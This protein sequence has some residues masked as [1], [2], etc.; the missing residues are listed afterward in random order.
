MSPASVLDNFRDC[1]PAFDPAER[2]LLAAWLLVGGA[3]YLVRAAVRDLAKWD[4]R[5]Y[6]GAA[7]TMV[8]EG[9]WLVPQVPFREGPFLEKP[10]LAM[11]LE[12]LSMLVVGETLTAVR[13][14]SVLATLGTALAVYLIARHV[15][16]RTAGFAAMGALLAAPPLFYES[17][18]GITA[19]TDALLLLFGTAFVWWTWRGADR[20][21]LLPVAGVAAGLAVLTKGVAAG[22]FAITVLPFVAV[23]WRAYCRRELAVAVAATVVVAVPWN[24]AVFARHP[25]VYVDQMV[26]SQVVDRAMG[27]GAAPDETLLPWMNFPY[28]DLFP[29]YLGGLLPASAVGALVAL[30]R[31]PVSVREG[32]DDGPISLRFDDRRRLTTGL[33]WWAAAPLLT[34]SLLGGNHIWYLLPMVAPT[35]VL[36]GLLAADLLDG[37]GWAA[38]WFGVA[39]DNRPPAAALWLCGLVALAV[40]LGTYPGPLRLNPWYGPP[41]PSLGEVEFLRAAARWLYG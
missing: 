40:L 36:A 2:R 4:E 12:A 14:P 3:F 39:P 15:R 25:S 32:L 9:A 28:F 1:C 30:W 35:A 31:P 8:N 24:V 37:V 18:S 16:N 10:P 27:A 23:R 5:Y 20:P 13:L 11:W 38:D 26:L 21:E 22:V 29:G 17:H 33:V 34:F 7:H 41:A 6:A 19:D